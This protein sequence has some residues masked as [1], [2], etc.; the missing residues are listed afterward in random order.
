MSVTGD[1]HLHTAAR[2]FIRSANDGRVTGKERN[3]NVRNGP[4]PAVVAALSAKSITR[5]AHHEAGHAVAAVATGGRLIRV[6]LGSFDWTT[7]DESADTPGE[8]DTQPWKSTEHSSRLRDLGRGDVDLPG[9]GRRL[10]RRHV[11]RPD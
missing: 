6:S 4:D 2:E 1:E 11:R 8:R 7:S 9:R 10:L 5:R 3:H